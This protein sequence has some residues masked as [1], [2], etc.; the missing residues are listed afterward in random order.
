M[1]LDELHLDYETS[2]KVDLKKQGLDVYSKDESTKVLMLSFQFGDGPVEL[3]EPHKGPMPARLRAAFADPKILKI[4]HNA[5][6]EI[7]ITVN[8]LG[9]KTPVTQ[10]R[11]TMVMALSLGLPGKLEMLARDAL[12]LPSK[13][14][15]DTEGERLIRLFCYPK[16]K[17]TW[18]THPEEWEKFCGYCRQDTVTEGRVYK[19][20][21]NYC[22]HYIDKLFKM[23]VIDQRI[24]ARGLPVD[25]D[26]I[27]AAE[28]IAAKAK[29][30]FK[31][32]LQELTGL[33]NPNSTQQ[34][35]PW[36][37]ER[38]YPFSSLGKNR[39]AIALKDFEDKI[40]D[41]A[42][43]VMRLRL[44]SNKTSTAKFATIR[45]FQHGG[46][47]RN[48]YQFRGA[49]ATGRY[50][51]RILGQNMPRPWKD[52]EEYLA[53]IREMIAARDYDG[54]TQ[55]FGQ[56]LECVVSS[57]RSSIKAP[58][59][60]Q[61]VVADLSSIELVVIAWLTKCEFW[62]NVLREGKDAYK[63]FAEKW[64]NV[65]YEK[66]QKWQRGLSK[67]PA[68][69][70]GY[71][72]GAGREKGVYPDTEKTGLWG[73]AA[74]MSVAMTKQQCKDAVKIYRDLSP[75][76]KQ[77]WTDLEEAAMDCIETKEKRRVGLITFDYKQPFLRMH[78]PSGR[79]IHYC[80]PRIQKVKMEYEDAKT[81]KLVVEWKTGMT[82][83]RQCQ[84]TGR[85]IRVSNHGGRYIEQATQGIALDVLEVGIEEA[86]D[87]GD[88]PVI[89][90]YHDEILSLVDE[91]SGIT[92]HDL[93]RCMTTK[94]AW[95]GDMMVKA[96]GYTSH[97][98]KKD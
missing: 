43:E 78:L 62:L 36:L 76:I 98:Y 6:F 34:L 79:M 67:P 47:L 10:W 66:V 94:R 9:I 38:G 20:L 82:Y 75:E 68:L 52:A 19:V 85:W 33:A 2:S 26:F 74:N 93:I 46:Y 5:A 70:C 4:A 54:L 97:F 18:E 24:N 11:C 56:P 32:V 65:P 25:L 21:L 44:M 73:Y 69:G 14:H 45:N 23:W 49:A 37:Q 84:T 60:K 7:A 48:T 16:A 22:K 1:A 90:H 91:D 51:G 71:R 31:V 50:A 81:G 55:F 86:E 96:A 63:A 59:G 88:M 35:L 17:A 72:M 53:E 77:A 3:W 80:R 95:M 41:E 64:L 57:I 83:E 8:V 87:F 39:V 58:K 29:A 61:L 27:A 30:E 42:K 12:K 89:G 92:H 40:T 13:Y 15:K 28:E